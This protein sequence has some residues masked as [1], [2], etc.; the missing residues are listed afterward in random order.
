MELDRYGATKVLSK[1]VQS[2]LRSALGPVV[3]PLGYRRTPG[4][5]GCSFTVERDGLWQT[6][7]VQI[8]KWGWTQ[9]IGSAFTVEFQWDD[10]PERGSWSD[11]R[12]RWT[13]L[14]RDSD[15][16]VARELNSTIAKSAVPYSK[17]LRED[18]E[19]LDFDFEQERL[20]TL[21]TPDGPWS[22]GQDVWCRYRDPQ[23]VQAWASFFVDRLPDMLDRFPPT[24]DRRAALH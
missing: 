8:D 17:V 5:S 13:G 3:K 4:S 7:W 11:A 2:V 6:F 1:D 22:P 21:C 10:E 16:A 14:C 19:F 12:T 18:R 23:H 20:N 24:Y 9:W 15:L